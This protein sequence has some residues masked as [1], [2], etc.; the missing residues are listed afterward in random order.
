MS[1]NP[2]EIL[3]LAMA[4]ASAREDDAAVKKL[5]KL[6]D[7][8]DALLAALG[9]DDVTQQFAQWKPGTSKAGT[10]GYVSSGGEFR[11]DKP[12]GAD[13]FVRTGQTSSAMPEGVSL[14]EVANHPDVKANP[15]ILAKVKDATRKAV[16]LAKRAVLEVS[17][18][19]PQI[20]S[21]WTDVFDHPDDLKKIGY[22]PGFSGTGGHG[23][24]D[25]VKDSIG[26][27]A[28]MAAGLVVKVGAAAITFLKKKLGGAKMA[29]DS[30]DE[31]LKEFSEFLAKVIAAANAQYGIDYTLSAETIAT[32]LKNLR[33]EKQAGKA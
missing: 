31:G 13:D 8:P 33:A 28:H 16:D 22:N 12:K 17:L 32:N 6:A 1:P 25:P 20:L 26:I 10:Q 4:R 27:P 15:G 14:S 23:T 18:H 29:D 9:D 7:D 11:K 19:S 21:A 24:S 30:S 3:T 5:A 2:L